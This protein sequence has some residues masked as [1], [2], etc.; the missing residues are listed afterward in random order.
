M[1]PAQ[2]L[3]IAQMISL[4]VT[5]GTQA[6][7]AIRAAHPNA[8][9]PPLEEVLAQADGNYDAIAAAAQAQLKPKV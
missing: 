9:I 7:N 5:V 4:G 1:D 3:Q 6:Y 8:G 2:A